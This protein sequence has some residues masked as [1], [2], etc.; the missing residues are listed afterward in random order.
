MTVAAQIAV[1]LALTAELFDG[2]PLGRMTGAEHAVHEAATDIPATVRA[3]FDTTEKLSNED[4]AT[5]I[6]IARNAIAAF[7]ASRNSGGNGD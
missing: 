4:R 2:V 1:L 3:R 5:I 6:Q 7:S